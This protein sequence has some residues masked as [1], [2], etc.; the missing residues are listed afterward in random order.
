MPPDAA[1]HAAGC[2]AFRGKMGFGG[3]ARDGYGTY[4]VPMLYLF[5][6]QGVRASRQTTKDAKSMKGAAGRAGTRAQNPPPQAHPVRGRQMFTGCN[7]FLC[8]TS[9]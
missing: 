2:Q 4:L 8:V 7:H 1:L 5:V 9:R 3:H 6:V